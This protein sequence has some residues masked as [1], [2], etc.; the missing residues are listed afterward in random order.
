MKE[1]R[2]VK[3]VQMFKRPVQRASQGDR[4]GMCVTQFD[5]KL[6]ERGIACAPGYVTTI[7]GCVIDMG[8][9][10]FIDFA[11]DKSIFLAKIRFAA[12]FSLTSKSL[13]NSDRSFVILQVKIPYFKGEIATKSKFHISLGHETVLGRLT[14]FYSDGDTGDGD[15]SL[16]RE[17]HYLERMSDLESTEEGDS[18]EEQSRRKVFAI[19]EF[20]RP[21]PVVPK[22]KGGRRNG[23]LVESFRH[24]RLYFSSWITVGHRHAHHL[25]SLGFPRATA[26]P[27]VI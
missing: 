5:A 3:S 22:C 25:L 11:I 21:V 7:H 2:K 20:D 9:S 27:T 18:K 10:I 6:L 1:V 8:R 13:Q 16:E 17:Y 15:F 26:P 23:I 12:T 19:V 24:S 14:L 4:I